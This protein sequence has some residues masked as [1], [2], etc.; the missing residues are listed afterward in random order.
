MMKSE[1]LIVHKSALPA[2][3]EKVVEA[4]EIL[5]RGTAREVSEAAR[6]AGIARSTYY[7]YKDLVF[8]AGENASRRKA[9]LSMLLNHEPGVLG[10][11]LSSLAD[12]GANVLTIM[13]NPPIR[14]RA[15][16]VI[17]LDIGELDRSVEETLAALGALT[18][19][20][21]VG[22]LDLE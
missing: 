11:V 3:Y 20:E 16:V 7:K 19:V 17:S 12:M 1:Y 2:C 9:V 4:R 18:G 10:R 5:R 22:L 13:Q 8:S 14:E 15:S 6:M 21:R